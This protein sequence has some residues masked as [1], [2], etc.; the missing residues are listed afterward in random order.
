MIL[1]R[2]TI[3]L[4]HTQSRE[5][6]VGMASEDYKT[7]MREEFCLI[8]EMQKLETRFWNHAMVKARHVAYTDRFHE[9][10]RANNNLKTMQKASTMTDETIRNGS[11]K[12]NPEKRSK[13]ESRVEIGM[14]EMIIRGLG[15]EMPLL[16]LKILLGRSTL[17]GNRQTQ[18]MANNRGQGRGNDDNQARGRTFMLGAEEA[19]QDPNIM[20]GIDP[21]DLGFSYEIEIASGQLVKIN[22]VIRGC[23]LEIEVRVPLRNSEV[24]RVIG[25]SPDE[26]MRHLM[27]AKADEHKQ[28]EIFVV[29][30]FF[31][32]LSKIDLRP[33]YHQLRVHEDEILKVTFR[34][35]YGHI[36]F[37]I[38]PFGLT[39]APATREEHEL[40]L[41]LVLE[42]LK[43]E[44]LYAKFSKCK[45]WLQEV[46]FLG[47]VINGVGIYVDP[48]KIKAVKNW[49]APRTPTEVNSFLGLEGY[50]NAIDSKRHVEKIP[51]DM[52]ETFV[53]DIDNI[54]CPMQVMSPDLE[55]KHNNTQLQVM[56]GVIFLMDFQL[57]SQNRR[58][59]QLI[60]QSLKCLF[61]LLTP[62]KGLT[63]LSQDC[64]DT[65]YL[66]DGYDVLRKMVVIYPAL[67][68]HF[69][70]M[71]IHDEVGFKIH[72]NGYFEFHPLSTS[73]STMYIS[74]CWIPSSIS[75]SNSTYP[76][77]L[78]R[79][80]CS[81]GVSVAERKAVN[82]TEPLLLNAV[83]GEDVER[84]PVWLMRQA[85]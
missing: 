15:L 35:C 9:L 5:V 42:P 34:T 53:V 81:A 65:S 60:L 52:L 63:F 37:T 18:T 10:A 46:Q 85:G 25:E 23:K 14:R 6:A 16:Q 72:K 82:T 40:H 76:P 31:E 44:K 66:L 19:H 62:I 29:R 77:R 41:G 51:F 38:M 3:M 55:S 48:S 28:E 43:K 79:I 75:V 57:E 56:G 67:A 73:M 69:G 24:L 74:S 26:K 33:R 58:I 50:V 54:P 49:E 17:G 36:E 11:L 47:H 32:F 20:T 61:L 27:S 70:V 71:D 4:I 22:K 59:T 12:K 45:F 68:K 21:S 8:N 78:N 83:R 7:L 1:E 84:P 2:S 30:D 64:T 80:T 39:N 13:V